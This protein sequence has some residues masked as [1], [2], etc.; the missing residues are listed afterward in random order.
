MHGG[1]YCNID[2]LC[3]YTYNWYN[4]IN[5]DG[6]ELANMKVFMENKLAEARDNGE[7]VDH[8]KLSLIKSQAILVIRLF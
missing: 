1:S 4:L 2:I 7:K 3:R 8:V 5:E 6:P